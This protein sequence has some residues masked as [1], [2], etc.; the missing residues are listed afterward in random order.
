M[1][2]QAVEP[3]QI[4]YLIAIIKTCHPEL[5]S[6]LKNYNEAFHSM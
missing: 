2:E 6:M 1:Q 3:E 4:K 5:F